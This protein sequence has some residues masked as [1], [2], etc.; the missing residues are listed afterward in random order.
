MSHVIAIG[1]QKGGAGKTTTAVNLAASLAG[2]GEGPVLLVDLDPQGSVAHYFHVPVPSRHIYHGL[3]S[4]QP[5][6]LCD[7]VLPSPDGFDYLLANEDLAAADH[8]L[9]VQ[10]TVIWQYALK[11]KLLPLRERY[12]WI[13]LDCPPSLGVLTI[14]ALSAADGVITTVQSQYLDWKA[15]NLF[16]GTFNKV[17]AGLNPQLRLL[18]LLVSRHKAVSRTSREIVEILHTDPH[19]EALPKFPHIIPEAQAIADAGVHGRSLVAEAREGG[20]ARQREL[21]ALYNAV[22]QETVRLVTTPVAV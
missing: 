13:I 5:D 6:A 12:S 15:V 1:M 18:G 19:Y 10:S 11:E 21:A 16:L 17:V 14:V 22:G 7:L 20:N 3:M 9:R 2:R 8:E 4:G